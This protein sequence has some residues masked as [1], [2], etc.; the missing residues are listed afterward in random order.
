M[1]HSSKV[2][3]EFSAIQKKIYMMT[4]DLRVEIEK[5]ILKFKRNATD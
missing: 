3:C 5:L 1:L 2:L 4:G